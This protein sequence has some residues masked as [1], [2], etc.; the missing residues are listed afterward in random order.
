MAVFVY[1]V[2]FVD[3]VYS[4]IVVMVDRVRIVERGCVA[5]IAYFKVAVRTYDFVRDKK[6]LARGD[7][8]KARRTSPRPGKIING[9]GTSSM[10]NSIDGI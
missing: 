6:C 3:I 4:A 9:I 5:V 10:A 8:E 2:N 7:L 1:V